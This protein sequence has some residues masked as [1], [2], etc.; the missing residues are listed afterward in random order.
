MP[1]ESLSG[2]N[3]DDAGVSLLWTIAASMRWI[4]RSRSSASSV[5]RK[6]GECECS[7]FSSLKTKRGCCIFNR[8][9][10]KLERGG[11]Q[12]AT[13]VRGKILMTPRGNAEWRSS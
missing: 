10:T 6:T 13:K 1:P 9:S 8:P 2:L 12:V 7:T 3:G 5:A 4:Q 11:V